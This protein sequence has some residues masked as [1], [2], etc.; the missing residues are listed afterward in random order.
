MSLKKELWL[1]NDPAI[2][3][4]GKY[5]D[6]TPVIQKDTC[7]PVFTTALFTTAKTWKQPKY[8]LTSEW[9]QKW[10]NRYTT[11]HCSAI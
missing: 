7:I 9:L 6:K 3:L 11:E 10:M 2:P 4:L 8:P 1:Q 5:P